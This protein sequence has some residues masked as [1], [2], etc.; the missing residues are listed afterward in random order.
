MQQWF[1]TI[2]TGELINIPQP[3]V[4][5]T[6]EPMK[7]TDIRFVAY[8]DCQ[9]LQIWLPYPGNQYNQLRLLNLA[10]GAIQFEWA[11]EDLL[12]GSVQVLIDS[13]IIP[14]GEYR[15]E[16]DKQGH[17]VHCTSLIKYQEGELPAA[18]EQDIEPVTQPVSE[19][20]ITYRDGQGNLIPD[21]DMLLREKILQ[22]MTNR[23]SRKIKYYSE[24]RYGKVVYVEGETQISLYYEFGGGECIASIDIPSAAEWEKATGMSQERRADVLQFIAETVL[25][26]QASNGRYEISDTVITIYRK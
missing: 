3:G 2:R 13:S 12:S 8:P 10:T 21:E 1:G 25:R 26:D 5:K 19:G 15:L 17:S 18:T 7:D 4:F 6:L 22:Q 11:V 16:I 24:G 9:Q 14:P 23:F 20:Y